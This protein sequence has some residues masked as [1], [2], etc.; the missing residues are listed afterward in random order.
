MGTRN[1]TS[2]VLNGKQVVC[3]YGQWDGYPSYTGVKI[4]EFLRDCDMDR[5]QKALENTTIHVSSMDDA[6]TYTGS[7]KQLGNIPDMVFKTQCELSRERNQKGYIDEFA[8]VRHLVEKGAITEQLAEDYL[9]ATRDTGCDILKLI[10]NRSLDKPPLE[11]FALSDEYN[12][13]YSWDIQGVYVLDLDNNTVQMTYD[14]YSQKYDISNLPTEIEKEMLVFEKATRELYEPGYGK[15]NATSA[16]EKDPG[17]LYRKA[18]EIALK[19]GEEIKTEYP[20]LVSASDQTIAAESFGH[21][22]IYRFLC[23]KNGLQPEKFKPFE[24][25]VASAEEKR[26]L[27]VASR[28]DVPTP[29]TERDC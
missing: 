24:E 15:E 21:T 22:M 25:L 14:G 3:Q 11:L 13:Q 8:T 5:F 20:K 2:V 19:I 17:V 4:L 7:T 29:V 23:E 27:S 18:S 10:Y 12:G 6:T 26:T 9:V 1:I 28:D 16:A